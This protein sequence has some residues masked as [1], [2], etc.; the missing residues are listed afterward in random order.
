MS[1][2]RA[3]A[4]ASLRHRRSGA[5]SRVSGEPSNYSREERKGSG[6]LITSGMKGN[7]SDGDFFL[8]CL[9]AICSF[10]CSAFLCMDRIPT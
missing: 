8:M 10:S 3:F 5:S 7:G 9:L 4:I 1:E 2:I 6:L